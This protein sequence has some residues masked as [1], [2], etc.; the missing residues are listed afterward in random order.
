MITILNLH[1]SSLLDPYY[2][3]VTQ[4]NRKACEKIMSVRK[5]VIWK[6]I[7][8]CTIMKVKRNI[9]EMFIFKSTGIEI[10][11]EKGYNWQYYEEI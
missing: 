6:H 10:K 8:Y 7:F 2:I 4:V 3:L 5:Q 9:F 1:I 11:D